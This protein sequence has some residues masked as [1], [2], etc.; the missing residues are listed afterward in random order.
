M[1]KQESEKVRFK[2]VVFPRLLGRKTGEAYIT[3]EYPTLENAENSP[4]KGKILNPLQ[5]YNSI[6]KWNLSLNK[7]QENKAATDED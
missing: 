4:E 7:K 3:G 1:A 2:K 5:A 6:T